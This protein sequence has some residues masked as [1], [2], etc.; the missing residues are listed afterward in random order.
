MIA[1]NEMLK[2][3]GLSDKDMR[4]LR[5]KFVEKYVNQKG[6]DKNTLTMEQ[7]NEIQQQDEYRK[8]GMLLS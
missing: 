7:L 2:E 1:K 3:T 5:E 4:E 6:W 8:P